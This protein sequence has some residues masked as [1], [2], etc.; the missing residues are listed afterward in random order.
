M[1]KY[2]RQTNLT[3]SSATTLDESE[4]GSK[5]IR[6]VLCIPQTSS[7]RGALPSDCFGS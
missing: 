7:I 4:L 2:S 6:E 5:G 3:L 1:I